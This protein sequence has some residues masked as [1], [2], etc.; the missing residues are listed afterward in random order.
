MSSL[1][2]Y[3]KWRGDLSFEQS[4]FNEVDNLILSKLSYLPFDDFITEDFERHFVLREVGQKLLDQLNDPEQSEKLVILFEQDPLLLEMMIKS[5]RF[6]GLEVFG[7]RNRVEPEIQKQICVMTIKVMEDLH[8]VSFR[9]TD[10]TFVGWKEDFNMI[11][12]AVVPSQLDA[13]RYVD[14]LLATIEG[15]IYAGGH[16][17]GGNMAIYSGIFTQENFADRVLKIFS[18]DAPGFHSSV[19]ASEKYQKNKH[20]IYS[21]IPEESIVG[22]MLEHDASITVI[23][24]LESMFFQHDPYNWLVEGCAFIP[25][26]EVSRSSRF[27]DTTFRQIVENLEPEKQR[28]SIDA[29]FGVLESTEVHSLNQLTEDWFKKTR[30]MIG[31]YSQY[32]KETR[33]TMTDMLG[34]L[35][36]IGRKNLSLLRKNNS[37]DNSK[38]IED[39]TQ[40]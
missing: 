21:F 22:M 12:Q 10:N 31:T 29:L 16:S 36:N 9:G 26:D 11:L 28:Q 2:D 23:K 13:V 17:K 39:H 14:E 8:F 1:F 7:F 6:G 25:V 5:D 20:K 27:F 32:D 38:E 30:I 19:L 37:E 40:E 34:M 4:S 18:N 35:F 3:I 33:K 24:S 15:N